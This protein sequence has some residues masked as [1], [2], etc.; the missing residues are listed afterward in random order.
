LQKTSGVLLW[1][2]NLKRSLI[3][4]P[5]RKLISGFAV[6][7]LVSCT[8]NKGENSIDFSYE[9]KTIRVE[10][11]GCSNEDQPC[12]SFEVTYPVFLHL[13]P[14]ISK[15]LL[16]KIENAIGYDNPEAEGFSI[17]KM[18]NRLVSDFKKF[19][20][21][22]SENGFGW[23]FKA[24]VDVQFATDSLLSLAATSEYFTG[25]AHGGY[26]VYF[27][28]IDPISG[29]EITLHSL[30]K[31]GFEE[32]LNLEG[33]KSFRQVKG[34]NENDTLALHGYEFPQG[35]FEVNSNY[36]FNK[37]G[38]VFFFNNYEIA[39]YAVGPTEILIPWEVVAT[40]RK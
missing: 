9:M 6:I 10:S 37:E 24:S 33:E 11:E 35:K 36:G 23:Y 18:G 34:L 40:L 1:M 14:E 13:A 5:I 27:V 28:N 3:S 32:L 26:T 29:E 4:N 16:E 30:L 39:S 17:E 12:T 15:T 2:K 19:Q 20:G 21:D 8:G 38:I 31:P 22:F 7:A 25:G